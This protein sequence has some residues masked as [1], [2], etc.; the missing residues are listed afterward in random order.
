MAGLGI[1]AIAVQGVLL[2]VGNGSS[3]ET[4]QTISNISKFTFPMKAKVV[5]VSN[6]SDIWKNQIPTLL[7]IGDVTCEV[8]WVMEDPT[9]NNQVGGLRNI[10][11]NK[12]KR[13]FQIIYNDGNSSTDAFKAYVTSFQI[14]GQEADVFKAQVTFSGTGQP[15]IV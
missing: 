4:F 8:F 15:S 9:L 5:D 2:Q 14:T 1:S 6:V 10:F 12:L 11:A 13:D 3:P 7:E